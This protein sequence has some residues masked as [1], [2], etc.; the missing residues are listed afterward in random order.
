MTEKKKT[1]RHI[2]KRVNGKWIKIGKLIIFKGAEIDPLNINSLTEKI[3]LRR[4]LKRVRSLLSQ[5]RT[6]ASFIELD[7]LINKLENHEFQ[8]K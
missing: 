1:I 6:I 7:S 8:S 3:L 4:R 5:G 2:R